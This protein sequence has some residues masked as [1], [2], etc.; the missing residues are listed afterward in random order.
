MAK[1]RVFTHS[2]S[3]AG[4]Y[5]LVSRIVDRQFLFGDAEKEAFGRMMRAFAAFHQVEILTYCL[6]SNHFHLLVRVPHRP[7]GFDLPLG[8]VLARWQDAVGDAW[9][10]GLTRQFAAWQ[11]NGS[12][13]AVEEWRQRMVGR[14]FSLT[15]FM[16]ALKQRYTQWYNRRSGRR[17]T[18]WEGRYKSVIVEDEASALRTMATYI[19]LNPV[20]AGIVSDPGD[21]RWSGYAEAMSGNATAQ[22]GIARITGATA[23]RTHGAFPNQHLR[24]SA[25]PAP[26]ESP[27]VPATVETPAQRRR[28]HLRALVH[29]REMLGVAGRPRQNA[30]GETIRRGLSEKVQARLASGS[31]VKREQLLRR[32]RHFTDGV[33][34][35]SR[36]F[37][38]QWFQANRP[39]FTGRSAATRQTGARPINKDWKHLYNLRQLQ[40]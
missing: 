17:G 37:I 16:K 10:R 14:M 25:D 22:E 21:Y 38:D 30:A 31:G 1:P 36:A 3:Q 5:H 40:G 4:V 7:A 19:D 33:I 13:A 6:M 20:R 18:L 32:V 11:E 8:E 12:E 23:E 34:L 28:R 39:W 27:I 29:Y 15:E 24:P 2:G 26:S 9:N 35:G